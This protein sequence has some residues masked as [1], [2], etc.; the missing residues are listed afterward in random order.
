MIY[1]LSNNKL[2]IDINS[3]GAELVSVKYLGKEK[4]WQ[5]DDGEWDGH[6][7]ILF[8]VCGRCA[9]VLDGKDLDVGFHGF[10]KNTE[11]GVKKQTKTSITLAFGKNFDKNIFPY[12]FEFSVTYK[13]LGSK[14]KIYQEVDNLGNIPFY[15]SCGSH[16]SYNFDK[17]IG[18]Y[19][20][21]FN[22]NEEFISLLT[23]WK[24]RL[25]GETKSFGSGKRLVFPEDFLVESNTI[26][27]RNVNSKKLDVIDND[28]N[29]K[30]LSLY[31]KDYPNFL[32]WRPATEKMV[33][34]EPW[35]NLP[36]KVDETINDVSQKEGF[37]LLKPKKKIKLYHG[38]KY[39]S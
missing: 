14:L 5:N 16:E 37:I 35:H 6:A 10:A 9:Y 39:Y 18:N 31:I 19:T 3:L 28:T 34:L 2:K 1:S 12:D 30:V 13:I 38:V 36:D 4:N 32:V 24:G 27:L 20:L 23:H 26:I 11:F 21:S 7:P 15:F 17:E 22:K 8:P 29:R 33:C 25:N